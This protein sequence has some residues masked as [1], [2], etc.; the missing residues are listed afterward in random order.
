M[1]QKDLKSKEFL[2]V[3]TRF[4]DVFNFFLFDGEQVIQPEDLEERDTEEMLSLYGMDGK[5]VQKQKWRDLLKN[6][7][8]KFMEGTYLV[9]L[10]IENQ[11]DIHYAM[12][13]KNMVYD[14]I[15]YTTQ[16][17]ETKRKHEIKNEYCT[18]TEFLSGFLKTDKLIPIITLT[19]YWGTDEWDGPMSIHEML[20]IQNPKLL[21]Y[22]ADYKINLIVP[23]NIR[24]FNKFRTSVGEV[25]EII[26]ASDSKENME[27]VMIENPAFHNLENDAIKMINVFTGIDIAVNEKEEAMDMCKAWEDQ[28]LAGIEIGIEK[29]IEKARQETY[30]ILRTL[31]FSDE[32]IEKKIEEASL[33]TIQSED[34]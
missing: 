24:D 4:A 18:G 13:V 29:G 11:S 28:K 26:K 3:N 17:E 27:K 21:K 22:I 1:G 15:N 16:I 7:V 10:G 33:E 32:E 14:A 2:S 12:P 6:A 31:G 20:D 9:L 34:R 19:M 5:E 23:R 8:V 25:L 30:R